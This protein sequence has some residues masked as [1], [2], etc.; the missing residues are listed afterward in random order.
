[1][2][3]LVD[4]TSPFGCYSTGFVRRRLHGWM[5]ET[6]EA[7]WIGRR[8]F[9]GLRLLERLCSSRTR[10]IVDVERFGLR[11]RLYRYGNRGISSNT[12]G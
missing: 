5:N 4:D 8:I 3:M 7:G 12:C 1:M 10:E 11:W 9:G 6:Y 2:T